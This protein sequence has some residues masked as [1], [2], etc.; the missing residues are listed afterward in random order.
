MNKDFVH[1]SVQ[2]VKATE[3][4]IILSES[5]PFLKGQDMLI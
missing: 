1:D 2:K 5:N 4:S 3:P